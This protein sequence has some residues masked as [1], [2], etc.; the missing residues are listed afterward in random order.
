MDKQAIF[1][2]EGVELVRHKL[3]SRLYPADWNTA[4]AEWLAE[5][6]QRSRLS[7]ESITDRQMRLAQRA[8]TIATVALIVATIAMIGAAISAIPVLIGWL[9]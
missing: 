8:N 3:S 7:S 6:D 1:Q 9:T 2:K 4:A 5:Q